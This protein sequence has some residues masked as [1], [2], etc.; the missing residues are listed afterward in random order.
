MKVLLSTGSLFYLPIKECFL[1]AQEAG[2]DG[3]DLVIDR[4]FS[5]MSYMDSVTECLDILPICSVHAPYMRM[6]AWGTIAEGLVRTIEIAKAIGAE[7]VNFHPPSW[8]SL[9]LRFLRWFR[10]V[11]DFQRD[12]DCQNVLLTVENMPLIGRRLMLAPYTLN[13]YRELIEFGVRRNLY[14]TFDTTHLGSFGGD[15]IVAVLDF[16]RTGRLQNVHV[17]DHSDFKSHQFVGT[18]DL[19]IV[20]LLNTMRRM[21]YDGMVTLELSPLELPR[22]P[23]WLVKMLRYQASLLKLHLQKEE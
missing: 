14:F 22:N 11:Q 4:N 13:D 18:G 9:E 21:G 7:V 17:S 1:L 8:Y 19:P 5:N 3:C 2:F 10:K 23:G 16:L 6:K 15:I 20:K 12:F